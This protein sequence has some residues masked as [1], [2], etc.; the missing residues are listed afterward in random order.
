MNDDLSDLIPQVWVVDEETFE[1]LLKRLE[2]P[3]KDI[4][5]LRELMARK[6]PWGK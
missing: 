1:W 5:E 2:E 6:S 4:L 3:P